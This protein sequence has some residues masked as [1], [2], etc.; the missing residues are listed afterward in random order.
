GLR[1]GDWVVAAGGHLL[2]EGE[3]VAPVDRDNRPIASMPL[4]AT[5]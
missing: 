5:P 3:V 1:A 4:K 2:R